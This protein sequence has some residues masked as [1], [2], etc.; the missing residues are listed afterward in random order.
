[1]I[2]DS[3]YAWERL[4]HLAPPENPLRERVLRLV[5]RSG[6]TRLCTLIEEGERYFTDGCA[7]GGVVGCPVHS[8]GIAEKPNFSIILVPPASLSMK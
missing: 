8:K 1:L 6:K 2:R 4:S 3:F 7:S 5:L